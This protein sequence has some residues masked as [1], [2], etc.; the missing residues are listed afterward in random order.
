[1]GLIGSGDSGEQSPVPVPRSAESA[2]ADALRA[3]FP[4]GDRV[5]AILVVTA[6][7]APR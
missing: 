7:T 3:Q 2:R 4:G 1:M 5:P 6:A